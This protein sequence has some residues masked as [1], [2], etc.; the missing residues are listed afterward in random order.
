MIE[1]KVYAEGEK[2]VKS[3][4]EVNYKVLKRLLARMLDAKNSSYAMCV[5][6]DG[7]EKRQVCAE[8][9]F[10]KKSRL[11]TA[12]ATFCKKNILKRVARGMYQ[13]NPFM[14]GKGEWRYIAQLR[15]IWNFN[16]I[17]Q[18]SEQC[19]EN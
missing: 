15:Y 14:F 13:F 2:V 1:V 4:S 16:K 19:T 7:E 11:D 17:V 6:L 12:L 9:G 5:Y 8:L 18:H 10:E 3:L